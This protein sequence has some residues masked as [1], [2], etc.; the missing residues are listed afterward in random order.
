MGRPRKSRRDLPP[1]VYV[2]HGAYY[3]VH[4]SGKWH[5]LA[6]IGNEREMRV[7]WATLEQPS[8]TFGTVAALIDEYLSKYAAVAKAPRTYKD[9][10]KDNDR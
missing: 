10:L 3:Y 8:E 4:L 9:N 1:R 5:R 7:A 2:K 6:S